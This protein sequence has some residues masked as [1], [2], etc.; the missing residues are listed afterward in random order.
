MNQSLGSGN[1]GCDGNRVDVVE[2]DQVCFVRFAGLHGQGIAQKEQQIDFIAGDAR[3]DLLV[4]SLLARKKAED[5][6][7]GSLGH[8]LAGRPRRTDVVL[9]EDAAVG[10]TELDHQFLFG[11]VRDQSDVQE[12]SSFMSNGP[13]TVAGRC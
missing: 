9:A 10:D 13:L 5:T 6:K 4:P 3:C 11:I 1:I 2:T 7:P 12:N 8:E